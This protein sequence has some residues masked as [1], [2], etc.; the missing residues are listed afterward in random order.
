[1]KIVKHSPVL[2]C[3][4]LA[5]SFAS[6]QDPPKP[7]VT[8][9]RVE[10]AIGVG[11][12]GERQGVGEEARWVYKVAVAP[13]ANFIYVLRP[14]ADGGESLGIGPGLAFVTTGDELLPA[15]TLNFGTQSSQISFGA[16]FGQPGRP[17]PFLSFKVAGKAF[18]SP[19]QPV[20]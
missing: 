15:A 12:L 2:F 3:I 20:P 5:W 14:R 1:M 9:L 17:A 19:G 11:L 6:A 16:V 13:G 8:N 4:L 18:T 7:K 10:A